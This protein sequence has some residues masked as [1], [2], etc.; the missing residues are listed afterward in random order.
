MGHYRCGIG[1]NFGFGGIVFRLVL[2]FWRAKF[3]AGGSAQVRADARYAGQ[4]MTEVNHGSM[5]T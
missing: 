3:M 5:R 2:L 4:I 1:G